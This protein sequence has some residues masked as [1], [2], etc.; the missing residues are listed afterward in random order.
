[1]CRDCQ[2]CWQAAQTPV[3]ELITHAPLPPRTHTHQPSVSSTHTHTH[4]RSSGVFGYFPTYS[5]GAMYATQVCVHTPTH[6]HTHT[7]H[8]DSRTPRSP[9]RHPPARSTHT[10]H[11]VHLTNHTHTR[12]HVNTQH[13]P[14]HNHNTQHATTTH[15]QIYAA[16]AKAIPDLDERIAAGDFLPLKVSVCACVYM[17][18]C[19]DGLVVVGGTAPGSASCGLCVGKPS[20]PSPCSHT[21]THKSP[22][23]HPPPLFPDTPLP[24]PQHTHPHTHTYT[25]TLTSPLLPPPPVFLFQTW[26]NTHIHQLGSLHPSGDDLLLAATGGCGCGELGTA[27]CCLLPAAR[28]FEMVWGCLV[29]FGAAWCGWLCFGGVLCVVLSWVCHQSRRKGGAHGGWVGEERI[30]G[31]AADIE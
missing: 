26:L 13:M 4:L 20:L 12:T 10:P 11:V 27:A 28:R 14:T 21:H 23:P 29:W 22:T 9:T 17:C 8:A 16:A 1:M 6:T 7:S 31:C 18:T 25:H 3:D 30:P 19:V 2:G 24:G 5:L 15:A